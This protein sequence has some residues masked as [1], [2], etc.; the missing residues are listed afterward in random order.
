MSAA[1]AAI[2]DGETARSWRMDLV[3]ALLAT[4]VVVVVN[5]HAGFPELTNA[6]GDNDSLLQLVQVRDL[7]GGQGWFDMHQYRM[8]PEGGFVMHWS[9]LLDAPLALGIL[10]M[11]ALTGSRPLAEQIVQVAWPALLF[12]LTLFFTVRAARSVGGAG[13]VL[14]AVVVGA[15]A[16]H[17]I[18]IY[19]PGSLDHHNVQVMLTMASL[20][21]LLD[22]PARN[23]MALP[24][25][26]CAALTLAIGMESAPYAG[27][28]GALVAVLFLIDGVRERQIAKNFGFGFAGVSALVFVTTVPMSAWGQ[29]QCD[30]FSI[31]QFVVAAIAGIGLAASASNDA[32]AS[33]WQRRLLAIGLLAA[34]LA[35][36]VVVA[37]PQC[38]AEPYAGLDPRLKELWLD[39]IDEAQSLFTLLVHKPA[40]VA[41][42]YATP[43]L[44][45]VVMALRLAHGG[46]RRQDSLVGALL[47][48]AFLVSA[49]E[50]RG[51]TFSIGFA[52]IPLS[53]WIARW[54]R[55]VEVSPSRS[56]SLRMVAAWL[57][58][59]NALWAGTA[60]AMSSAFE[61]VKADDGGVDRNCE[62][63]ASFAA[64]AGQPGTTVLAISNL[65][66]PIL[67]YTGHRVFSGPYHRNIAGNLLALD[68]FLGSD[69]DARAIVESHH[70]GLVA[71]CR[72]SVESQLLAEKAPK[73]FLAGLIDGRVPEW[74]EPVAATRGAPIELYR[75]REGG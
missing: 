70:V 75:V 6:G 52:V 26:V 44:A 38:L 27:T 30:A 32:V 39:H 17:F 55:R 33:R 40:S 50:I 45:I 2:S 53:A 13:A 15:A 51:S 23:W 12:W 9:R 24:A 71:V 25:G 35:A 65:G 42:R 67:A 47:I 7:L 22:A 4:L 11:S 21:L 58:S 69:A 68:A 1:Q 14:P 20:S 29:A 46:R 34:T 36:V 64:L 74:L 31:A 66:S 8:G 56:V 28:I 48:V 72:G 16:Y 19:S 43:L 49:W 63:K 59:V 62:S 60:T 41:A 5:A 37:F 73:G 61:P 10:V 18:G 57:L 54:R 3:A